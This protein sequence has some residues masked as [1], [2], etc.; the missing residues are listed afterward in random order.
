MNKSLKVKYKM[1]RIK[2]STK[3]KHNTILNIFGVDSEFLKQNENDSDGVLI[4]FNTTSIENLLTDI[5]NGGWEITAVSEDSQ[6]ICYHLISK[7]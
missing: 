2:E 1:L 6:S 4:G 7:V 5:I 3:I